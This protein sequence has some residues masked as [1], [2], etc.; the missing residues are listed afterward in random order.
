MVT[1]RAGNWG[2][3]TRCLSRAPSPNGLNFLGQPRT[4]LS[5]NTLGASGDR[6]LYC[7]GKAG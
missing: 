6:Q 7:T 5:P 3:I 4:T 1:A 2:P